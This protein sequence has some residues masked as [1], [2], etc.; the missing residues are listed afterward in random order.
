MRA[1]LRARGRA[2]CGSQ[3]AVTEPEVYEVVFRNKLVFDAC[4]A[5]WMRWPDDW[6]RW[7]ALEEDVAADPHRMI[8]LDDL[9]HLLEGPA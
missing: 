3:P 2:A 5:C 9:V 8:S 6:K 7:P 1:P 4:L